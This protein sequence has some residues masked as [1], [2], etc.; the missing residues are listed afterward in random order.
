IEDFHKI[1]PEHKTQLA[2]TMKVFMDL[3]QSYDALRIVA[4]GA[5]DTAREVVQADAEMRHRLAEIPV[6]LMEPDELRH[7]ILK[8]ESR[9]NFSLPDEVKEGIVRYASGL[10][11]VCHQLCLNIC[12]SAQI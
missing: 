2:Q 1:A 7:I 12:R 10:A 5:V 4:I 11:S 9:P 6:P 8:G 3:A